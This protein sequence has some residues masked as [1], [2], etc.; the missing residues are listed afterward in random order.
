[1]QVG[2]I[3]FYK[4]TKLL[5]LSLAVLS[6]V[7]LSLGYPAYAQSVHHGKLLK[8]EENPDL[9]VD[10]EHKILPHTLKIV[11]GQRTHIK[12]GVP[13]KLADKNAVLLFFDLPREILLAPG[14]R[15]NSTW[16]VP[17]KDTRYLTLITPH[18]FFGEFSSTLEFAQKDATSV[19]S[20]QKVIFKII[21]TAKIKQD[22]EN[23]KQSTPPSKPSPKNEFKKQAKLKLK[24]KAE[25]S[26]QSKPKQP[27]STRDK[28]VTSQQKN[29]QQQ[30]EDTDI[31]PELK[32]IL[33]HRA[34]KLLAEGYIQRARANYKF[35]AISGYAD[36]ALWLAK[37]YDPQ[38]IKKL[39]VI[40]MR[41]N[42]AK[43]I[44]WYKRA[45]KLGSKTAQKR[46][47]KLVSAKLTY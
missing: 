14:S 18:N 10:I 2:M 19:I 26:H 42:R 34:K 16:I 13:K 40:G 1:M 20:E 25:A 7:W 9:K 22:I 5:V 31:S 24:E 35:V 33:M 6:T 15:I 4:M 32:V 29:F 28:A 11:A 43:A 45:V 27:K 44:K 3:E 41:P 8:L 46:L 17:L 21:P 37:T 23:K 30:H 36:A 47:N 39:N 38:E 12:L